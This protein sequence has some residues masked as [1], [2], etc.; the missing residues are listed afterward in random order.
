MS[1]EGMW[2]PFEPRLTGHRVPC[3]VPSVVL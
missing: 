1:L 2:I 3:N